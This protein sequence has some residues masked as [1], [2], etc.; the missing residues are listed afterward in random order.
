MMTRY[1]KVLRLVQATLL[2]GALIVGSSA[3]VSRASAGSQV[4]FRASISERFQG[5]SACPPPYASIGV[6]CALTIPG[7]SQGMATHMGRVTQQ[8]LTVITEFAS[9]ECGSTEFK[10]VTITAANG[11]QVFAYL[12]GTFCSDGTGAGTYQI[13]GGTGRFSGATGTG[14]YQEKATFGADNTGADTIDYSGTIASPGSI[15]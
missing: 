12:P 1:T 3:F 7:T 4:P 9:T 14:T 8:H 11:D 10:L 13:T 5:L 2:A 15:N 6:F